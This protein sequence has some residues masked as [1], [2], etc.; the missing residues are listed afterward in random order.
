VGLAVDS[1]V[2]VERGDRLDPGGTAAALGDGCGDGRT[3]ALR[4]AVDFG[5]GFGVGLGVG[6]GVGLGVDFGVGLGVGFGV[7]VGIGAVTA[8]RGG[9]TAVYVALLRPFPEPL[10]A[11][12]E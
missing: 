8:T 6:F 11:E 10:V 5:V 9:E 12:K 1:P 2:D 4:P 7:G 3:D